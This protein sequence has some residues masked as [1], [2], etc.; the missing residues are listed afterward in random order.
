MLLALFLAFPRP[1]LLLGGAPSPETQTFLQKAAHPF[2]MVEATTGSHQSKLAFRLL[3]P[4]LAHGLGLGATGC[5]LLETAFG[6]WLLWLALALGERITGDRLCGVLS[7]LLTAGLLAGT[8][9]FIEFRCMFD[10]AAIALLIAAMLTQRPLWIALLVFLSAWTDER[11]FIGAGL[12]WLFHALPQTHRWRTFPLALVRPESLAVAAAWAAYLAGRWWLSETYGLVMDTNE[13]GWGVLFEQRNNAALGIWSALE[14]AWIPVALA[15]LALTLTRRWPTLLL[16]LLATSAVILA[17]LSV[18]DITRS[19]A[20]L[21]PLFFLALRVL[22][23]NDEKE[24]SSLSPLPSDAPAQS[25]GH[26]HTPQHLPVNETTGTLRNVL[27][28][29]TLVCVLWPN[30]SAGGQDQAW[31]FTP[32]LPVQIFNVI[33]YTLTRSA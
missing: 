20:Y 6:V 2:T 3:P 4:V 14:G 23:G 32:P 21:L 11:G 17:A 18:R 29:A 5:K 25:S 9:S 24:S 8:A 26:A 15:G 27:Y 19:M 22:R 7:G 30:I 31:W 13:I 33:Y 10:G 16:G 12:V 28:A 1:E